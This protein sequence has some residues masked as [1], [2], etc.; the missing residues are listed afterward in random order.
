[1][2]GKRSSLSVATGFP[3]RKCSSDQQ[4]TQRNE[5]GLDRKTE[6]VTKNGDPGSAPGGR[7]ARKSRLL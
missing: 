7:V 5:D 2:I 4:L 1:M 3:G 6:K